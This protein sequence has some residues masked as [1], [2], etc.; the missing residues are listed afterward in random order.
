MVSITALENAIN[1][2]RTRFPSDPTAYAVCPQV[3]AL[4][5]VYARLI[6]ERRD[7]ISET[8]LNSEQHA[9]LYYKP[10]QHAST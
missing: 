10:E 8:E 5:D 9:A 1:Y 7:H 6:Y 2:W 3:N 4:A